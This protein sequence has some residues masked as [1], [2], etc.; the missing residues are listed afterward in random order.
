ML[1]DDA[2]AEIQRILGFRLDNT[3]DIVTEMQNTQEFLETTLRPWFLLNERVLLTTVASTQTVALPSDFLGPSRDPTEDLFIE[4]DDGTLTAL[5]R[6][7]R[8]D[9]TG[10]EEGKPSCYAL[11]ISDI[12]L[13][14]IPD[15]AYNLRYT[16]Y[17]KDQVLDTNIENKWLKY[18]PFLL[19]G[20]TGKRIAAALRSD[21]AMQVFSQM[22]LEAAVA[23]RRREE[24]LHHVQRTYTIGGED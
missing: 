20:E 14:P 13:Y 9:I 8:K 16:Y 3:T 18:A 5:E 22:A 24:E 7:N 11:R 12:F 2:V 17:A 10:N 19:I 1:R 6:V 21:A 15:A 4:E 23:M